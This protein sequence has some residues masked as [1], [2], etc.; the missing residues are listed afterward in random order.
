M[1]TGIFLFIV[2]VLG[3]AFFAA[4]ETAFVGSNPIRVRYQAEKANDLAARRLS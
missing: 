4:D 2:G 3:N 1:I